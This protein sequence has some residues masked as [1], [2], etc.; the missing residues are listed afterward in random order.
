V[1]SSSALLQSGMADNHTEDILTRPLTQVG[2]LS[3]HVCRALAKEGFLTVGDVVHHLPFR[4]EDRTRTAIIAFQPSPLPVCHYVVVVKT[5]VK[6]FGNRRGGG[7]FEAVVEHAA[8]G[9]LGHQLTLRWWGM[10]FMSRV[11]A[12]G[13]ELVVHGKIK[14]WKVWRQFM[15]VAS[16]RFTDCV[17]A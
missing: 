5:S 15:Q 3:A 16:R 9:G 8:G 1:L 10:T 11:I 13:Q 4:H 17:E 6:R 2:S 12:E 14:E 7:V